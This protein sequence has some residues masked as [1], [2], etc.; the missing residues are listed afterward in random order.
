MR[1]PKGGGSCLFK[2]YSSF[3]PTDR[4]KHTHRERQREREKE[5]ERERSLLVD[6]AQ[7]AKVKVVIVIGG[8]YTGSLKE[9]AVVKVI[10]IVGLF[11]GQVVGIFLEVLCRAL[12]SRD[13]G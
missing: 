12:H 13:V 7:A 6:Q 4:P 11:L 9:G 8:V 3:L 5:R 2:N 1:D 10:K